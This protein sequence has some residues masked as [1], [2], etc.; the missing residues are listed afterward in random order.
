MRRFTAVFAIAALSACQKAEKPAEQPVAP[1]AAPAP[2]APAPI[3]LADVAGKWTVKT[4]PVGK[5]TVLLT[6]T[7]T[8]TADTNGWTITFPGRAPLA[9]K[10]SVSGDSV[11]TS[12][13]PYPSMLRKG[14]TVT[15]NGVFHLVAGKMVGNMMAHYNVKTADSVLALRS[16][17]EKTP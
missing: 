2:A 13:G 1:A 10:V 4:M 7:L 14:V 17:G 3:N 11:M 5:D 6:Y 12:V 8:A 9:A 15:T 16:M